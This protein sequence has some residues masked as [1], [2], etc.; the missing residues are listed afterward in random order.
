MFAIAFDLVVQV[1]AAVHPKG[2]LMSGLNRAARYLA[3]HP[4]KLEH[5]RKVQA[6]PALS[7]MT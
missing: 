5:L 4:A 7:S 3:K 1:T 6:L 2:V